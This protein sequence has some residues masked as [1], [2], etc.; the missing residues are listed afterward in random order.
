MPT[1]EKKTFLNTPR[2][3]GAEKKKL[4]AEVARAARELTLLMEGLTPELHSD[5][6]RLSGYIRHNVKAAQEGFSLDDIRGK[7]AELTAGTE[8]LKAQKQSGSR[9]STE[10]H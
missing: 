2:L 6:S 7:V 4:T 1:R 9:G 8:I 3:S 5:I 10:V